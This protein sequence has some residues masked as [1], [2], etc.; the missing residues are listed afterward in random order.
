MAKLANRITR[1]KASPIREI[2]ALA[3]KPGVI[4]FAGGLPASES[5]P[6]AESLSFMQG[7]LQYG[8]SEGEAYLRQYVSDELRERGLNIE[9]SSVL[10]LSGSQ[11]GIDLVGKLV[12]DEGT[13]VAVE[14]PTYLAALQVFTLF[15][16]NYINYEI[17]SLQ[18]ALIKNKPELLYSIPTF[19][20]P[21][22]RV[23]TQ[24][25]RKDL[26]R[27]CEENT[28]I[29]FEDDPYRDLMY[30]PCDRQPVCSYMKTGSW[31]Y[32]S[33]FS[34]TVA[35]GLRIAYLVCSVDLYPYL[36]RLKQAADLHS[37]RVSQR[38]VYG[39]VNDSQAQ[40][41]I[42]Q[43]QTM[44]LD[45]RDDFNRVLKKHFDDLATWDVPAGGLFYWLTLK[46]STLID[47]QKILQLAIN[48][49]VTF[50]PGEPFFSDGRQASNCFRL[51]FSSVAYQDMDGGLEKLAAVFRQVFAEHEKL[52]AKTKNII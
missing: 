38:I 33:T 18:D 11:Q 46:S 37:S 34:K 20:N 1:L 24:D 12:V 32:Q 40:E 35:P 6:S 39:I 49:G 44:Y 29:L 30:E 21:S 5:F 8:A 23:Y 51:N 4:S 15:G 17:D 27:V 2:L 13:T 48:V 3:S 42:T 10:I 43:L 25:Q 28:I 14:A 7:D 9:E 26:A 19:Q 47:T 45:K 31:I 41:R 36:L 16:A 50:M 52:N 22:S